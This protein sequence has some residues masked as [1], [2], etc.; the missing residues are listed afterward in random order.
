[1]YNTRRN[2][3][4]KG[5]A[6]L[7]LP[8]IPHFAIASNKKKNFSGSTLTLRY[9][10]YTLELKH[11]FGVNNSTR[12]TT[13]VVL[14]EIGYE[15]VIGYGE[16]SMPPYLGESH[17]SVFAFL[18]MVDITQFKDPF[19]IE[20]I[21]AYIDE[22]APGNKAAKASIDIALHDLLGKMLQQPWYK[23]WGLSAEKTP[24]T[25]FTIGLDTPE[26][27]RTKTKEAAGF[28]ILKVKLSKDND[29]AMINA[30]RDITNVPLC[31]D[32]NQGWADK[33][34]A[35]DMMHWMHEKG[36]VFC[37]QPMPIAALDDMAWVTEQSPI[38]TMGDESVQRLADVKKAW[39]VFSGINIKL[40]KCTG[41]YE[42]A[43]MIQVAR[44][45]D[46]KL[47]LGCMT[48]TSCAVSAMSQLAPLA[49]WADLDGN[50]LIKNDVYKGMLVVDGKVT[51][52]D[53]AGIGI[54]ML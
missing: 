15:G 39:K 27:V 16:A 43:K 53:K 8:L 48:E 52:N 30:V 32:V 28:K 40:M 18:S 26:M 33:N 44:A 42:A 6:I 37:E 45:L 19:R 12:T 36:V 17:E 50:F 23:I 11:A 1:M 4:Q 41:L 13:P 10:A 34:Y 20:E 46:M 21:L 14:T 51:L 47:M 3:L 49:D 29:K 31:V 2:F 22:L 38:P 25:S 24:N 35:L 5:S 7:T 9:R 54:E